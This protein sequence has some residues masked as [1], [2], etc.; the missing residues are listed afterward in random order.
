[1][2]VNISVREYFVNFANENQKNLEKVR[3]SNFKKYFYHFPTEFLSKKI[4]PQKRF[5]VLL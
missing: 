2:I 3:K 5:C 1:M 4:K